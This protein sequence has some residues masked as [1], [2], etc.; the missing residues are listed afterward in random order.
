LKRVVDMKKPART[1]ARFVAEA[2]LRPL[3]SP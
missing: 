1:P 3:V 2:G